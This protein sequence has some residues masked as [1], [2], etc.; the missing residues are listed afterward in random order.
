M[1]V[2][3]L[4]QTI[5]NLNTEDLRELYKY[6]KEKL[7]PAVVYQQKSIRCGCEKCKKGMIGHGNYWYAYFTYKGKTRCVYIGKEKREINPI[8]EF[9][10][11]KIKTKK[12][13]KKNG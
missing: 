12:G 8:E 2:N 6:I 11:R 5:D 1:L 10:K 13:G 4:L 3:I 9:K 7:P